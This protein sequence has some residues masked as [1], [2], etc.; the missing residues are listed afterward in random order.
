MK[1]R[2]GE[3]FRLLPSS[4]T[5]PGP[6]RL[7]EQLWVPHIKVDVSPLILL[8]F[9]IYNIEPNENMLWDVTCLEVVPWH[10]CV[11]MYCFPTAYR[12]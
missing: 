8:M 9:I 2:L 7:E 11:V 5:P 1:K 10:A 4:F 6:G 3:I 12:R